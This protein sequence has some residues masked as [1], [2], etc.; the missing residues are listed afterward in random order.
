MSGVKLAAARWLLPASST[1]TKSRDVD[2]SAK[3][4]GHFHALTIPEG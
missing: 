1:Y 2:L 3:A 4:A